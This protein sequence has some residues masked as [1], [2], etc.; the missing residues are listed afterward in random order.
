MAQRTSRQTNGGPLGAAVH[1]L[2]QELGSIQQQLRS[3]GRDLEKRLERG[4]RELA[5]RR[6]KLESRGRKQLKSLLADARR[7][8]AYKRARSLTRDAEK[9]LGSIRKDASK[10][11]ESGVETVLSSIQIATKSDVQ[12]IDRRLRTLNR[13]LDE[14]EKARASRG[15]SGSNER[16]AAHA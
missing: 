5:S 2:E 13:K 6:Q 3:Q 16:P 4:R 12:R 15:R 7:S 14:L 9:R 1:R 11:L 8:A 10:Q